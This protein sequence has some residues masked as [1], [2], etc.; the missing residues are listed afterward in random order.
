L[1]E[2]RPPP[3][4]DKDRAFG[5]E[6]RVLVEVMQAYFRGERAVGFAAMAI[7][8][9]AVGFAF[10]A[11]RSAEGSFA[12]GLAV[13]LLIA[14]LGLSIG[15]PLLVVRTDR[16]VAEL[17]ALSAD[18]I[19]KIEVPRMA[20]VNANWSRLKATW[21]V[22]IA[23]GLILIWAVKREWALGVGLSLLL[24]ACMLFTADVFAEKRAVIYTRA[25]ES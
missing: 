11:W 4:F 25:L 17:S 20:K 19:K 5:D 13:P 22:L 23:I 8:L 14:G 9:V 1:K 16:Q 12:T 7:G 2:I 3:R 6:V 18:E 21:T 24:I 10:W 15:G